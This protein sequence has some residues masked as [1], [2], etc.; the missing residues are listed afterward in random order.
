MS[1]R[2]PDRVT[3]VHRDGLVLDVLDEGPLDGDPVVLL[4]G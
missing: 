3:E 4:H 2:H 1:T